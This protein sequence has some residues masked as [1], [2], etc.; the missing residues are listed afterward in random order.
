VRH[1]GTYLNNDMRA[2]VPFSDAEHVIKQLNQS[3][4]YS[5]III[6]RALTMPADPEKLIR[7]LLFAHKSEQGV[8]NVKIINFCFA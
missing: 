4:S 1:S 6:H 7:E 5:L 2:H 3:A 8:M